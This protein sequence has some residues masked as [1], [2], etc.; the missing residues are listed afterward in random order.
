MFTKYITIFQ[1]NVAVAVLALWITLLS[2]DSGTK[3]INNL[4]EM[5]NEDWWICYE[6]FKIKVVNEYKLVWYAI[7]ISC[8]DMRW[9]W[10]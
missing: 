6:H 5:K 7:Y 8:D 4:L 3:E 9:D 1:D 2:Q 10:K